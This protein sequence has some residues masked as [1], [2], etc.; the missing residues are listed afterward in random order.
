MPR[1][2]PAPRRSTRCGHGGPWHRLRRLRALGH[3]PTSPEILGPLA[4]STSRREDAGQHED[5]A[6]RDSRAVSESDT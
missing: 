2:P 4:G 3:G 5:T 1:T 6:Q